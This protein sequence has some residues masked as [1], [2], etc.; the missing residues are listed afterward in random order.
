MVKSGKAI[1]GEG[2]DLRKGTEA[3]KY[4]AQLENG[5]SGGSTEGRTPEQRTVGRGSGGSDPGLE[6]TLALDIGPLILTFLIR[7]RGIII[8]PNSQG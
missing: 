1:L 2:T 4:R 3:G 8:I 6:S 5:A 7:E